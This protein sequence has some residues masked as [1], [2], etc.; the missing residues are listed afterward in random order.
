[1]RFKVIGCPK[2]G[3]Q[4][5]TRFY[6]TLGLDVAHE[7]LASQGGVGWNLVWFT[8]EFDHVFHQVR[9]PRS[10]IFNLGQMDEGCC[11]LVQKHTDVAI[12][13]DAILCGVKWWLVW[14]EH[15]ESR[16]QMTY[17]VE[18]LKPD[19]E[20]LKELAS[21]LGFDPSTA[22]VIPH[23]VKG[24]SETQ[25]IEMADIPEPYRSEVIKM[26]QRYGYDV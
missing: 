11:G 23:R 13:G 20:L 22:P 10:C 21:K 24:V 14:N 5:A 26:A 25:R 15:C 17:R 7:A 3:T 9:D 12:A 4:Y 6:R 18:D 19:T 2:S 8:E 1:M 16:A